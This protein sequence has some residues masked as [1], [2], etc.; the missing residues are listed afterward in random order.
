MKKIIAILTF[1]ALATLF[2][3]SCTMPDN[4]DMHT[5]QPHLYWKDINVRVVNV[6]RVHWFALTHQYE[7][8]IQVQSDEYNLLGEDTFHGS[9]AFG[10]PEQWNYEVGDTVKAEL[11]S[12]VNDST[13]EVVRRE[14]HQIY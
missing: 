6:D 8:E 11:Y 1:L 10:C 13:G 4:S 2:L 7:V 5:E 14:I 12:W 3:A 9:G